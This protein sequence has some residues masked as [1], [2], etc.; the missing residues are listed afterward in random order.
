MAT[1]D[2]QNQRILRQFNADTINL[3]IADHAQ[4]L[5]RRWRDL[6]QVS[7]PAPYSN[8]ESDR[9][10]F[11]RDICF[12][13]DDTFKLQGYTNFSLLL[14]TTSGL[15]KFE[16]TLVYAVVGHQIGFLEQLRRRGIGT[17]QKLL[18][19][20]TSAAAVKDEAKQSLI[21]EANQKAVDEFESRFGGWTIRPNLKFEP[22]ILAIDVTYDPTVRTI[23]LE[24][25][26]RHSLDPA[27]YPNHLETTSEMLRSVASAFN[28]NIA[29]FDMV[30]LERNLEYSKMMTYMLDE[31][32]IDLNSIR[33]DADD[34]ER[35]GY[36]YPAFET[37][38]EYYK[39]RG[40]G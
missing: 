5:R 21:S 35:W 14:S 18:E 15:P 31:K 37:E 30:W 23:D 9:G 1:F 36:S 38:L 33:I 10:R 26:E 34:Y 39:S 2:Q 12:A 3:F 24:V 32:R 11:A 22:Q 20:Q 25:C 13:L 16:K 28:T 27:D 7:Y 4:A 40:R 17:I 6:E 19:L 8:S 29:M